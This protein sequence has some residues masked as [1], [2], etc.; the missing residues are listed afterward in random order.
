ML[1]KGVV[2]SGILR[3]GGNDTFVLSGGSLRKSAERFEEFNIARGKSG[4][5][6]RDEVERI[7]PELG[8]VNPPSLRRRGRARVGKPNPY[9]IKTPAFSGI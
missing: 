3:W 5:K 9:S 7:R 1:F 2:S 6:W 4:K 8:K